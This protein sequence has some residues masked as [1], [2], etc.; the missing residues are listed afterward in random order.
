MRCKRCK[1]ECLNEELTNGY[2]STCAES[3]EETENNKSYSTEYESSNKIATFIEIISAIFFIIG[4]FAIIISI[5]AKF[6]IMLGIICFL[7]C[8]FVA[9][10][11]RGFAEIIQLLEDI[12]NK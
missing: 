10:L 5:P 12:K 11:L 2:C 8:S 9:I 6:G 1:M 7:S 4:G 3:F